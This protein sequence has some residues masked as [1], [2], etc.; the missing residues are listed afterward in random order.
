M[1]RTATDETRL[2]ESE[3]EQ[4]RAALVQLAIGGEQTKLVERLEPDDLTGSWICTSAQR[5]RTM[6]PPNIRAIELLLTGKADDDSI[7]IQDDDE[8]LEDMLESALAVLRDKA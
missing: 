5:E 7:T 1:S 8:S 6:H 4:L 2:A 3:R